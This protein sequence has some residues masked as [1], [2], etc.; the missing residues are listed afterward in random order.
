[1]QTYP[2]VDPEYILWHNLGYTERQRRFRRAFS[3]LVVLVII[4]FT[5]LAVLVL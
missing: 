5:I 3:Y 2:P 1:M 4:A